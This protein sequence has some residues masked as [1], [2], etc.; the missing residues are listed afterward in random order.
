MWKSSRQ[1][2]RDYGAGAP[3]PE[4]ARRKVAEATQLLVY[5][6][7]H[8]ENNTRPAPDRMIWSKNENRSKVQM[9]VRYHEQTIGRMYELFCEVHFQAI[10]D[11]ASPDGIRKEPLLSASQ[12][13]KLRPAHIMKP[14]KRT[15]TIF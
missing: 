8:H 5:Q 9:Q 11:P 13:Y 12:F 1:H 7:Y 15:G 10:A 3:V 2:C 14:E 4:Q 6:W